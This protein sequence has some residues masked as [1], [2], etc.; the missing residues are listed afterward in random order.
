MA[1]EA[2]TLGQELASLPLGEMIYSI[3][4]A[5]ADGQFQLDKSSMRAAEFMSGQF[6]L[7]DAEA[8][9]LVDVQGRKTDEPTIVDT[10]V[11]FGYSYDAAGNREANRLSMMELGFI[12][13][14]YQFV[15]TMIEIKIAIQ[16]QKQGTS[17]LG[18]TV[19]STTSSDAAALTASGRPENGI[20]TIINTT[21]VD[22][23]YASSYNYSAEMASRFSTKLVPVPPPAILEERIR[24]LME[25][26]LSDTRR[27][28]PTTEDTSE[29][30]AKERTRLK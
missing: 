9:H 19:S 15:D 7:R 24:I 30:D 25:Q 17:T 18:Q 20:R 21:P 28:E 14:F 2:P 16:L 10:R 23:R 27:K 22:A 29:H 8:G 11:Y 1:F 6:L 4:R 12:P 13:T 3:A 26:Q 5:I